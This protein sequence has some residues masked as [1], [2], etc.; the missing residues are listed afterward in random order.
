M[1]TV[2]LIVLLALAAVS[3]HAQ[4]DQES[5]P[6]FNEATFTGLEFRSI[7]PAFMS[8]RIADIVID[9]TDPSTWYVGV[10]SGGVWK[11]V[12]AG[13]TWEPIFDNEGSYSIGCITLD[14]N[15]PNTVWV[16][17]GENVSGRHVAYGD[18]IYRSRDGG[19]T[20]ENMGLE[21]S[22]RIGMIRIDPRDSD[23]I[24][25]AAQGPLWS[26]GGDRG[27]YKSTDGGENWRKVLGEGHGNKPEDDQYTGVNEV[28]M[29]PRNPD[30]MYAVTWQRLRNVAVLI[31]GG[32]GT[33]IHKSVD[34]GE[35]WRE[36][37]NGLPEEMMGKTGLAISPQ[38]PDVIYATIELDNRTGGFWRSDD[39]GENWEKKN[40]YLSSATGPH[41]YQEIFASPHF[42]GHVYQMDALMRM[43]KD[44]GDTF[45]PLPHDSKHGDHH[46]LAF[47]EDDRNYLLIGTDG[48]VYESFDRGTTWRFINNLP[49]TQY[50][51][52]AIDYDEPFYNVYGGTQDNNSQG[53][54]SRTVNHVGIRNS[55]WF[56]T[57]FGD[58][59]QSAVDPTNPDIIYAQWQQGNLTRF[60]RRTGERIYI[61]PQAREGE[62][63]DRYNWDAPILISPHDS[64]TLYFGTQRVWKSEN[65]GDSWTP[66]SGDLT[67]NENRVRQPVMDRTWSYDAPRDLWAMSQFNTLV[68][69]SES[70][71]VEGLIYAGTDDG[72]IQVTE[73]G[74]AN[75]RTINK[76]PGVPNRFFVNDIKADLHDAD[77]VYVVVDDHK[78]GDLAPYILK[79]ENRGRSW[80]SISGNLP[81]RHILWRVVQDHVKPDL[82]FV[83]SEFGV[84]FTV[85]SGGTWTKLKGGSP[86]MSFRDLV[87]QTRENDLVGATFGRSFYVLDDYTPLREVN[88]N[89]LK[90]GSVLFPVRRADWYVPRSPLGCDGTPGCK[91]SQGDSFWT[92]PNPLFGATFTYYLA[93]EVLSTKDAR[94]KVEKEK[95]KNNED[96]VAIG[97]DQVIAESREDEPAI[98][99]TV[100]DASGAI[101]DQVDAPATAGFNRVAWDL[102]Y[103]P[104]QPWAPAEE[105]DHEPDDYAGVLVAPGR[106]SVTMHKRV[107]GELV[108]L[109]QR[110]DFDVVSIRPDPVIPG[111]T[112]EQRVVYETQ[113]DELI[114]AATGTVMAIDNVIT[115]LDA[116]K[117]T[118]NRSRTD[119]SM[120]ELAHSLQQRIREQRD[121]IADNEARDMYNDLPAMS[122]SARLWHARFDPSSSAHG[123]TASQRQSLRLARK[124]Y[125]ETVA[126]L[127]QLVDVEY[128]GLKEAMD[129]ARVPWTP[130]RSVQD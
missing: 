68:N 6:G 55:D 60:D 108:D 94:R 33:G 67:R 103:P 84:F 104:L 48:G 29:D 45:I 43:T 19:R 106:Y 124:L 113:V 125:D 118:L 57:M 31:D 42:E 96:V 89:M 21:N 11:T 130:G 114:R 46:A 87:I 128:E 75:W 61:K 1:R 23:T 14:P 78:H 127:K 39:A 24:F 16:G 5:E 122:V 91:A 82:L 110:Q 93:E 15:D 35:T 109:G 100:S 22:E 79:S 12:N 28:H 64:K 129:T 53:G 7:G 76:L 86:N 9:P 119:G 69:I 27:L 120:Y 40:D 50:Y 74:G 18:G 97:W 116:V 4:E 88:E 34:G 73:D 95:E 66:I 51:K 10:G 111:S 52:V 44:G 17:T 49:I 105:S 63:P 2:K 72:L 80:K 90:N 102:R 81:D 38:D 3:A 8:G 41:Y 98:V 71:L 115:E 92:A 20:W 54:P 65:Y 121:H 30:V 37:T 101:V 59:H 13:T 70:P 112:Q 58:G 32:P 83:G 62:P 36:L 47:R 126:E 99:F 107:N 123:P 117:A 77:T 26:G 25:V 85:N 56:V